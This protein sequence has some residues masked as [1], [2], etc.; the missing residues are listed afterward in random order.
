MTKSKALHPWWTNFGSPLELTAELPGGRARDFLAY[1]LARNASDTRVIEMRATAS[2]IGFLIEMEV[3]RPQDLACD[4][5]AREPLIFLFSSTRDI[6]PGV[7]AARESFPD[8]MHQNWCPAGVPRSLCVDDRPW[9]EARLSYTPSD[10]VRR[11]GLWLSK[12]ARGEL[13]DPSQPLDPH[14]FRTG[15]GLIIPREALSGEG[16]L[17][18]LAGWTNRPDSRFIFARPVAEG[19][20]PTFVTL[21]YSLKAVGMAGRMRHAPTD[22]ASLAAELTPH[23]IDLFSDLGQSL[24]NMAGLSGNALGRLHAKICIVVD[25]PVMA[26]GGGAA[27]DPRAFITHIAAGEVGVSMG[28]LLANDSGLGN[29][30]GYLRAVTQGDP[31]ALAPVVVEPIDVYLKFDRSMA[32]MIAGVAPPDLR[33]VVLVGAGSLGSQLALD[34]A[35][36]GRFRWSVIDEDDLLPHNLA[37]H[38]LLPSDTGARKAPALAQKLHDLLGDPITVIR[39]DILEPNDAAAEVERVLQEA[40]IIIDASA[41]VAVARYLSDHASA[42]RRISAFFNPLGTDVVILAEDEGRTLPLRHLEALYHDHVQNNPAMAGHL[43]PPQ[44]GIRYSGSCRALTNRIPASHAALL[45]A[46]AAIGIVQL[47]GV[48]GA[49]IRAWRTSPDGSVNAVSMACSPMHAAPSGPWTF[50]YTDAILKRLKRY[51]KAK[52]PNETGGVLMG[53]VDMEAHTIHVVDALPPPPDSKGSVTSFERGIAGLAQAVRRA[54]QVSLD[55]LRY[56]GE[57]H[58][59]PKGSSSRPSGTDV[60]QLVWLTANLQEDGLPAVMAIVARKS[61]V[62]FLVGSATDE[63]IALKRAGL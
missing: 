40:D 4:I 5:R 2:E 41:S 14:F 53:I 11:V 13:H 29:S 36:E 10:F 1:M 58:S 35:R 38:G 61:D 31:A 25:F 39:A 51:R 23:G 7:L 6:R 57:W 54:S 22:L 8:T 45:S 27:N 37:R 17:P 24:Q 32:A 52:L 59:H 26:P 18:D 16:R 48:P 47:C 33:K 34:L 28:V 19:E 42:A 55:Q 9:E 62:A 60:K 63:P 44:T 12:A 46:L 43:A 15:L 56:V 49:S 20:V 3:E 30:G 50:F 21:A